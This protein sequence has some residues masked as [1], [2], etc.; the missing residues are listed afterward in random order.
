MLLGMN[1][2]DWRV[3]GRLSAGGLLCMLGSVPFMLP[4]MLAVVTKIPGPTPLPLPVIVTLGLL[5]QAV[6]IV[7]FTLVGYWL[8]RKIGLGAPLLE[9]WLAGHRP[10]PP[11]GATLRLSALLGAAAGIVLSLL[12][13]FWLLP[14]LPQLPLA[15]AARLPAWQRVEACFG[16]VVEELLMRLFLMSL[17]AWLLGK[18]WRGTDGRPGS[19]ALWLANVVAAVLFGLGHLPSASLFLPIT[20]LV[21]IAAL[22]LNGV[23]GIV[24]GWLYWRRGIEAAMAAHFCCGLFVWVITPAF[25]QAVTIA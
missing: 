25:V 11:W 20:P 10:G 8:A 6:M 5:Q 21:V 15:T 23:A 14:R 9:G 2:A 7:L 17:L 19:R 3:A 22:L 12:L 18:I 4:L 24:F 1:K 16:G 13:Y